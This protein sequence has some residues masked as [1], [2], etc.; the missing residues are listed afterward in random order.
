MSIIEEF[1][2]FT[3]GF[4]HEANEPVRVFKNS[5]GYFCAILRNREWD[6]YTVI[7]L[8]AKQRGAI[9]FKHSFKTRKAALSLY[10]SIE[11]KEKRHG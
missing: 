9:S 7:I 11:T 10:K 5:N 6:N 2:K 1:K 4:I 3:S 8:S